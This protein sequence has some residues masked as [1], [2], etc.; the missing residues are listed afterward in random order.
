MSE[1]SPRL[2]FKGKAP[3]RDDC[4]YYTKNSARN[5]ENQKQVNVGGTMVEGEELQ[6]HEVIGYAEVDARGHIQTGSARFLERLVSQLEENAEFV[7][8]FEDRLEDSELEGVN[9][10][11]V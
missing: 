5:Y 6:N 9:Q 1:R 3:D 11:W 7:K 2:I 4:W 10:E 8:L